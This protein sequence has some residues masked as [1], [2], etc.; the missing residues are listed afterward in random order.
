[1]KEL[2]Q[3]IEEIEIITGDIFHKADRLVSMNYVELRR[4]NKYLECNAL[5][6]N[7]TNNNFWLTTKNTYD[8]MIKNLN[9][10]N[11]C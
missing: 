7:H 2:K 5:A 11:L 10:L 6:V 4:T 1:M 3:Q 8:L 9:Y